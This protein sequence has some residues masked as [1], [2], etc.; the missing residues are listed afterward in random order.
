MKLERVSEF[1]LRLIE[2]S[3]GDGLVT[4]IDKYRK[5]CITA[6]PALYWLTHHT[7]K[8][9][10]GFSSNNLQIRQWDDKM[11]STLEK[12]FIFAEDGIR[13]LPGQNN[14][15]IGFFFCQCCGG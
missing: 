10:T 15:V 6:Q 2:Q 4:Q 1:L 3:V 5:I 7:S 13:I 12:R 14:H 8:S 9:L 11:P